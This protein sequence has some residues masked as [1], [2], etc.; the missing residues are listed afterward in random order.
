MIKRI[1]NH[2]SLTRSLS[3]SKE[4]ACRNSARWTSATPEST[5]N[6]RVPGACKRRCPSPR[7]R[8]RLPLGRN[9][10]TYK[11]VGPFP[12]PDILLT[13][14]FLS[15][16]SHFSKRNATI[17][18]QEKVT[19][20]HSLSLSTLASCFH[21]IDNKSSCLPSPFSLCSAQRALVPSWEPSSTVL[22]LRISLV[23]FIEHKLA[24]P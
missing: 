23:R 2:L 1:D 14:P 22:T 18:Q 15:S 7:G 5:V 13:S 20:S 6:S 17:F 12:L 8:F 16:T 3:F 11:G 19:P 4:D 21:Q 24:F 9:N 10:L